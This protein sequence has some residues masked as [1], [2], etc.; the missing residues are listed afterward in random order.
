MDGRHAEVVNAAH[1]DGAVLSNLHVN[2]YKI[3]A[4]LDEALERG[5]GGVVARIWS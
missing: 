4:V 2:G 5:A 1:D 3:A